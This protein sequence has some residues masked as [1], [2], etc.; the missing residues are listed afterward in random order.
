MNILH[1]K[2]LARRDR[3]KRAL[4]LMLQ[5]ADKY[6]CECGVTHFELPEKGKTRLMAC[7][8]C[9]RHFIVKQEIDA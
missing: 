6:A 8:N 1:E 9:G 5:G 3:L 2:I 4:A 7:G